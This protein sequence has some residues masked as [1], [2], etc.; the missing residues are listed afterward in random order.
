M[1]NYQKKDHKI[2]FINTKQKAR[3]IVLNFPYFESRD[4]Y[5]SV[6]EY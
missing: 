1:L 5:Q 3:I 2:L 6:K 4:K